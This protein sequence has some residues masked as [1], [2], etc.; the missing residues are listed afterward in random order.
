MQSVFL[1]LFKYKWNPTFPGIN[2]IFLEECNFTGKGF[3]SV[4]IK[5]LII[6]GVYDVFTWMKMF[7]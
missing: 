3:P 4:I 2:W 5:T 7:L 6:T 1:E